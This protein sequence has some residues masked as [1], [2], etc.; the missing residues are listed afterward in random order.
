MRKF[1][2]NYKE[3]T[4]EDVR[5]MRDFDLVLKKIKVQRDYWNNPW[6]YGAIGFA[7]ISSLLIF[8]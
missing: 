2:F 4:S 3:P 5:S 8:I 7:S 6:F 1:L